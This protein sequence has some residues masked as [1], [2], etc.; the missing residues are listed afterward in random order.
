M[1]ARQWEVY[2]GPGGRLYRIRVDGGWL[3]RNGEYSDSHIAFVPDPL[4]VNYVAVPAGIPSPP[5]NG[6][7]QWSGNFTIGGCPNGG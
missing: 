5:Y 2:S 7:A 4:P 1:T 6:A 3:Y